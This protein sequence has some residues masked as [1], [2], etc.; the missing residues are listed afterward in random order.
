MRSI[1]LR[2]AYL[3][4]LLTL[5]VVGAGCGQTLQEPQGT[6]G[7]PDKVSPATEVAGDDSWQHSELCQWRIQAT[8]GEKIVLNVTMLDL[9]DSVDCATS[10]VEVRDG[11]SIK[12]P[13]I[14]QSTVPVKVKR[15]CIAVNGTF[16]VTQLRSVTCR[17]GPE[18]PKKRYPSFYFAITS[19]NVYTD[20]DFT[21]TTRNL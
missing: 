15:Y 9:P 4:T 20:F 21:V 7:S 17:S 5:S 3:V 12:S 19:V 10:Y 16:P 18:S 2:F 8:H 14:G 1:N 13:L 6:F 11:P